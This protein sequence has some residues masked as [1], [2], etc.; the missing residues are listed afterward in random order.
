MVTQRIANPCPF[1]SVSS[2]LTENTRKAYDSK[3]FKINFFIKLEP[4]GPVSVDPIF[5]YAHKKR[6]IIRILN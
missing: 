3:F 5:I 2:N 1:G 6:A 4:G